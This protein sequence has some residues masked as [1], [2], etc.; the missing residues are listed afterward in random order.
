MKSLRNLVGVVLAFA[1]AAF[2]APGFAANKVYKLT[3]TDSPASA[4]FGSGRIVANFAN[5]IPTGNSSFNSLTFTISSVS[6]GVTVR[7][8]SAKHSASPTAGVVTWTPT[9][10]TI[11]SLYPVKPKQS[12]T[13]TVD[14]DGVSCGS[15]VDISV[16]A[17]VYTGSGLTGED[18]YFDGDPYPATVTANCDGTL[19]CGDT[20][21][22]AFAFPAP[23]L[24]LTSNDPG[25][26]KAVRGW[27]N[28]KGEQCVAV[29]Y[30][31]TNLLIVNN[32]FTNKWNTT[33]APSGAFYYTV[34]GD[35]KPLP[36]YGATPT[37]LPPQVAWEFNAAGEPINKTDGL[38]C[39]SSKLPRPYGTVA[40]L[41]GT[42]LVIDTPTS[43]SLP[44]GGDWETPPA[45]PF[46]I[47]ID[48]ERM[49]VTSIDGNSWTVARG[50]A[51]TT[52]VGH[53]PGAYVLSTPLP[54]DTRVGSPYQN[55]AAQM[56]V[57]SQGW[58]QYGAG[59]YFQ[60]V[61]FIDIGDGWGRVQ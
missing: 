23:G 8:A 39:L 9:T 25:Y 13:V 3:V 35:A 14:L 42:A 24:S 50:S 52:S 57:V 47:Y 26:A 37:L 34:N 41:E 28:G 46:P 5:A 12:V 61:D 29:D 49:T 56:C 40:S 30:N 48:Q 31:F 51:S 38:V 7:S 36:Q 53:N 45:T 27:F 32:T 58:Q 19:A 21:P 6:S 54:V 15:T 4:P 17:A 44:D 43:P 60:F 55:K 18:F 16:D 59:E 2:A 11:V 33:Q 22:D 20:I 10:V 1:L